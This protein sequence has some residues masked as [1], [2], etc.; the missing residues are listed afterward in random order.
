MKKYTIAILA[1]FIICSSFILFFSNHK[2]EPHTKLF[3]ELQNEDFGPYDDQKLVCINVGI[4]YIPQ[5]LVD[6]FEQLTGI[7]VIV[8]IFDSNEVLEA[9]L[10]AGNAEYDI[11]FP[12]AWPNFSRQLTTK[13]YKKI[14]QD[15][16]DISIFD[17]SIMNKL[18]KA[19]Q[20][21][22]YAVPY[23]WGISG[24]GINTEMLK[25]CQI[26]TDK[27]S[28]KQLGLSMLFSPQILK[29]L[30]K[31]GI[32]LPNSPNEIF[33]ALLAY[34]GLPPESNVIDDLQQA[35]KQFALIKPYV[36]KFTEF[37]FEDLASDNAAVT[38]G[39]SGDIK[40][41]IAQQKALHGSSKIEFIAPVHGVCIWI[42]VA[43]IPVNCVREKNAHAF[44]KFLFHP[45]IIAEITNQTKRANAVKE[46]NKYVDKTL[47]H[48]PDIYPSS[49][50]ID[51][52]Y[53][54]SE[55]SKDI[56]Y[57]KTRM[58]TKIKSDNFYG[59]NALV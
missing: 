6:L 21:N 10:L 19:D 3:L 59:K 41:I 2:T 47:L 44:L 32:S 8:D 9:K 11:V 25:D 40:N 5:Y 15:L 26:P 18:S 48:D 36:T 43:A 54:E 23:Q 42:D 22:Q 51:K 46:A 13:I 55:N 34:L 50:F 17:E 14:N 7:T 1:V 30:S 52:C 49:E 16:L 4:D 58:F 27:A 33:H 57:F 53:T 24:I 12:T 45:K 56:E 28:L 38:F 35:A 29:K 31:H 20:T 39:T 37:G